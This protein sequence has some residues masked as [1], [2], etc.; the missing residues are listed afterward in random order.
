MRRR[1][2]PAG[3]GTLFDA[4]DILPPAPGPDL[5]SYD[6]IVVNISGG[7]DSQEMLRLMVTLC[8]ALG[9]ADRLVCVYADL[10]SD[11][12]W[13]GTEEMARYHASYYGLRFEVVRKGENDGRPVT[14]LEHIEARGLWP[15]MDNRYCTSDLKRDPIS[16]VIT[17]LCN[18][19]R[20]QWKA[21]LPRGC[22]ARLRRVRVLNCMGLRAQES[23]AR[24]LA[25]VFENNKRLTNKSV[26]HVDNWLP[27]H[28]V[29]EEQVWTGIR[30][31][32]VRYHPVY[33]LGMPRLSCRF[34][35][36][37]G[38]KALVRAAQLDPAG[39]LKRARLEDKFQVQ[40]AARALACLLLAQADPQAAGMALT[41]I[42]R[43]LR[44]GHTFKN[45][46]SMYDVI[47][48]AEALTARGEVAV[49]ANWVG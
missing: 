32:G 22:K 12:E 4:A 39:A 41:C 46:L 7:K 36:L 35:V 45:G 16:T 40:R 23:P 28:S 18:E 15:D 5:A 34:C 31:S 49:A 27:I 33:D 44:S 10:G 21:T 9:V 3:Q 43:A 2:P 6:L 26:K 25:P 42:K 20:E 48:E 17:R 11:D 19:L 24:A 38:R 29:T 37:A 30:E 14:L 1:Q 47:A 8:I 13:P